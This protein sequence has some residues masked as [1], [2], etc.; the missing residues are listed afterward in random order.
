MKHLVDRYNIFFAYLPGKVEKNIHT[1][2]INLVMI[3]LF[4]LQFTLFILSLLRFDVMVVTIVWF[5]GLALSGLA[6]T[7]VPSLPRCRW[8]APITCS[9]KCIPEFDETKVYQPSLLRDNIVDDE[10]FRALWGPGEIFK[11]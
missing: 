10:D 5:I 8:A 6:I 4:A 1:T 11:Q 2:A 9:G 3:I 7:V